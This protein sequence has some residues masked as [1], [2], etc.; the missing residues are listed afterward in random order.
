MKCH[1]WAMS[2]GENPPLLFDRTLLR[3]RRERAAPDYDRFALLEREVRTMLT[4]RQGDINRRFGAVLEI[5]AGGLLDQQPSAD[6]QV[7]ID[8]SAGLLAG[9]PGNC[10]AA[11]EEQLPFGPG[12]F[13]LVRSTLVMQWANDLPGVLVQIKRALRPD[14]LFLGALLGGDSLF[15]LRQALLKAELD[16]FGRVAARV[17]PFA[18]VRDLGDLLQRTGFQMPM[19]DLDRIT[20]RYKDLFALLGDLRGTGSTNA[21]MDRSA[22]LP[23]RRFFER[24]NEIYQQ[25]FAGR[26]GL[27]PATFDVIFLTGWSPGPDQPKPK[28]PGS[29]THSLAE[30]LG[31]REQPLPGR[32]R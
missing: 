28:R 27:L 29:A 15:E 24:A 20:I 32:T 16:I 31:A 6:F 5:G 17:S 8:L 25:E 11:D 23:G 26:D 30:A 3:R 7:V 14:G 10:V 2:N 9:C 18:D 22:P 4:D 19:A 13:D 21:L 12:S 1:I